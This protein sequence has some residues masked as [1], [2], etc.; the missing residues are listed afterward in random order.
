MILW[1]TH[2]A[3]SAARKRLKTKKRNTTITR[4][5]QVNVSR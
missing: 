3:K 1:P 4:K 5:D 2:K